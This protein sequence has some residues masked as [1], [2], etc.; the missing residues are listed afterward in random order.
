[1]GLELTRGRAARPALGHEAEDR[2]PHRVT[3][4]TEL[5]G[6]AL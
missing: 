2:E 1:M 6:M 5:L 3:E 4:C